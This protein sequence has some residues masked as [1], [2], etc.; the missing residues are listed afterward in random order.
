MSGITLLLAVGGL[1]IGAIT[2]L[3][4]RAMEA[5][6]AFTDQASYLAVV[7]AHKGAAPVQTE[8]WHTTTSSIVWSLVT[9]IGSF[10][11]GF[12]SLYRARLPERVSAGLGRALHP[13]RAAHSGHA[14]DYIAWLT[15]GTAVIGGLF[16]ISF[17]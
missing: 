14:G 8:H 3:A 13:L 10:V 9:L 17:R 15:F 6:H 2:P 12:A 16:A 7:L 4:E 1:A 11:V 5:A